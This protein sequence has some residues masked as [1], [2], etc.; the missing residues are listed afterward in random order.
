MRA[1]ASSSEAP[2]DSDHERHPHHPDLDEQLENYMNEKKKVRRSKSSGSEAVL[3]VK[4]ERVSQASESQE[5][6]AKDR[7]QRFEDDETVTVMES[8][9]SQASIFDLRGRIHESP[10]N[11]SDGE[12]SLI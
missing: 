3:P 7:Q 2:D 1:V 4:G 6:G 8:D 5:V 9:D 12:E 11:W 10:D